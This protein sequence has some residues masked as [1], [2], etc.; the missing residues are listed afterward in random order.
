MQSLSNYQGHFSK[1]SNKKFYD[2][3]HSKILFDPPPREMEIQTKINK[4]GLMK[5]KSFRIA[6]ETINKMNIQPSEW[7]KIFKRSN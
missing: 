7:E 5:V 1:N 2:I 3:N 6:K 4:W